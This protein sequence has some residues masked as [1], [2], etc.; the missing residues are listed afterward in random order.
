VHSQLL[1]TDHLQKK[2]LLIVKWLQV[3]VFNTVY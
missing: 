3:V 2:L 1:L